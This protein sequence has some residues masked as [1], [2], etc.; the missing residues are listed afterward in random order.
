MECCGVEYYTD[1]YE[2]MGPNTVTPGCCQPNSGL[3]A[4][5]CFMHL[6]LA[7]PPE[8]RVY[9]NGCYDKIIED[10]SSEAKVLTLLT[11][12]LVIAQVRIGN[13]FHNV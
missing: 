4:A 5:Y 1:W 2:I 9:T 13:V 6:N 7:S 10:L 3:D 8:Q 12:I 11:I